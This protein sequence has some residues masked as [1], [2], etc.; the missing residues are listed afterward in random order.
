M[1][2]YSTISKLGRL[3]ESGVIM[4]RP[5]SYNQQQVL[6]SAMQVFWRKGYATTSVKDLTDV[7]K[8]QPGSLYGA[9]KNKRNLFVHALDY[10]YEKLYKDIEQI[11][12]SEMPP[13][14]RI[15]CFF[16][17][18]LNIVKEDKE[19]KSCLLLNTLIELPS[20]DT[21][22][23]LRVSAMFQQ[24]EKLFI[25]TLY[26]AQK[27]GTLARG[28]IPETIAK[29]LMSGIFGLQVYNKMQNGK[30]GLKQITNNLL[31]IL[32]KT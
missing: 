25:E 4:P 1:S 11:L 29:M 26:E 30:D 18:F 3:I 21:E 7:T 10:Y 19:N 5:P 28:L 14:S 8:L 16:N 32:E 13:L 23:N 22:I 2:E 24:I 31:S 15:R 17:N 20:E 12:K 9:F 27:D 6:E